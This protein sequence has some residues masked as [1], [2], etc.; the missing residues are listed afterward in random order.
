MKRMLFLSICLSAGLLQAQ[1]MRIDAQ[2]FVTYVQ[3]IYPATAATAFFS[4]TEM[5]APAPMVMTDGIQ[6]SA[7]LKPVMVC[8]GVVVQEELIAGRQGRILKA[9]MQRDRHKPDRWPAQPGK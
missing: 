4:G 2:A 3:S 8:S 6:I 9:T 1:S 7:C 5:T